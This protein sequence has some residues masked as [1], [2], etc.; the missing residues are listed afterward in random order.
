MKD[1]RGTTTS[2]VATAWLV[3]WAF[4]VLAWWQKRWFRLTCHVDCAWCQRRLHRAL[5]PLRYHLG[6]G[7]WMPRVSHSICKECL[8]RELRPLGRAMR[9]RE[10]ELTIIS[11]N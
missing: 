7:R 1:P 9:T 3:F 2:V 11:T 4:A 8:D 6:P 5:M 10:H